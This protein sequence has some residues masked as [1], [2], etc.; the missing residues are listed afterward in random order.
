MS[1]RAKVTLAICAGVAAFLI[2]F[3][4]DTFFVAGPQINQDR[5]AQGYTYQLDGS[6]CP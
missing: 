6:P 3:A 1:T 4:A 5:C 2:W